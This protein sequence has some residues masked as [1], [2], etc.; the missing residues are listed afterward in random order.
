VVYTPRRRVVGYADDQAD[1]LLLTRRQVYLR[2]QRGAGAAIAGHVAVA[3]LAEG[4]RERRE[5][6][7]RPAERGHLSIIAADRRGQGGEA[8][9]EEAGHGGLGEGS[10]DQPFLLDPVRLDVVPVVVPGPHHRGEVPFGEGEEREP[11]RPVAGVADSRRPDLHLA[12]KWNEDAQAAVDAA[13]RHLE[14]TVAKPMATL[15][16]IIVAAHGH[17]RQAPV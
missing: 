10:D 1:G 8:A 7:A 17:P 2:R 4:Y 11:A 6:T 16:A 14:D 5:Q 13:A 12:L 15:I 9:V 3:A